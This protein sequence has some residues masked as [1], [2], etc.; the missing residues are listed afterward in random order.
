MKLKEL[1]N[2]SRTVDGILTKVRIYKYL[3]R[4]GSQ[5]P[6]DQKLGNAIRSE[7]KDLDN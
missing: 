6:N 2:E 1:L 3:K 7:I 4:L 5:Y